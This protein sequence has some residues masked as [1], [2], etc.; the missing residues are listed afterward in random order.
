MD[1]ESVGVL[2]KPSKGN[3]KFVHSKLMVADPDIV[4]FRSIGTW[5]II[6]T[7][8]GGGRFKLKDLSEEIEQSGR[9]EEEGK[10]GAK[11]S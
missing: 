1:K 6:D 10:I 11:L 7:C 4:A 5:W 2:G 9:P 3:K 8:W